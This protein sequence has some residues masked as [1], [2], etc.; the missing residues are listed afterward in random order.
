M[1][2]AGVIPVGHLYY[3]AA[4]QPRVPQESHLRKLLTAA[5]TYSHNWSRITSISDERLSRVGIPT[6]ISAFR[7]LPNRRGRLLEGDC[8][9][10]VGKRPDDLN[11][12]VSLSV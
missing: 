8:R 12:E 10:T 4:E 2:R 1:S 7:A 3:R 11:W 5:H 6:G 9:R